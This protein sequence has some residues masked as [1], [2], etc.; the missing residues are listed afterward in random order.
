M[1]VDPLHLSIALGPLAVYLILLGLINLSSRPQLTTGARDTAALAVALCGLVVVG[2]MELFLPER[3]AV[4]FGGGSVVWLMLLALYALL[5]CLLLLT[6]RPRLVIY[7]ATI[8]QIRPTLLQVI[9]GLDGDAH[10][11]G[12]S[13]MMPHLGVQLHVE[14]FFPMRTVLLV[15]SGPRQI[16]AGWQKLESALAAAFRKTS[17]PPSPYGVSLVLLGLLMV[18]LMTFSVVQDTPSV[19]QSLSEMLRQ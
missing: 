8:E 3:A 13:V 7:N 5:V 18:A 16:Y 19:A 2:P 11:V 15:S 12:D 17:S 4:H 9:S 14:P 6:L 1:N 10:W